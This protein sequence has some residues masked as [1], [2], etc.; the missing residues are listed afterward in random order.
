MI[1]LSLIINLPYKRSFKRNK[2][3]GIFSGNFF[4]NTR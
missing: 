4:G 3:D 2:E 1:I